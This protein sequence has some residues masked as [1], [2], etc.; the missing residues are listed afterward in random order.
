[1]S[2]GLNLPEQAHRLIADRKASSNVTRRSVN[3]NLH[4]QFP[5]IT[6]GLQTLILLTAG[7][8]LRRIQGF[9]ESHPWF[10]QSSDRSAASCG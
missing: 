9:S 3:N 8:L 5:Q 2:D 10:G 1:M 7:F 6:S 4:K